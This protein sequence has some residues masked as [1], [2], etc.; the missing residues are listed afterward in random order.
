MVKYLF[1]DSFILDHH[2]AAA[3]AQLVRIAQIARA[4]GATA[5]IEWAIRQAIFR[6]A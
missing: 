5:E 4:G 1:G 6:R 3:V 2:S